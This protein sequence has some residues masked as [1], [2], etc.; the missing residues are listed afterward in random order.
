MAVARRPRGVQRPFDGV[1]SGVDR[2]MTTEL[3][4]VPADYSRV[5]RRRTHLP[6]G[7]RLSLFGFVAL[8]VAPLWAGNL[9]SARQLYHRT[10]YEAALS[11]LEAEGSQDAA[12]LLLAGQTYY[13]LGQYREASERLEKA[14]E[15]RPE[16]AEIFLWLGRS[17]GR[18]AEASSFFTALGHAR[19][20]REALE[21]AVELDGKSLDAMNDLATY[22]LEAP[23]FLGGGVDKA[24]QLAS[25]I[26]S[27]DAAAEH[28]VRARIAEKRRDFSGAEAHLQKAVEMAPR[29]VDPLIKL[30]QF[31][32]RHGKLQQG[33]QALAAAAEVAPESPRLLFARAE[34]YVQ[35]RHNL[36]EAQLLLQRYLR[37]PLTPEDPPRREAERLLAASGR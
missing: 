15:L 7:V 16:S 1:Q 3:K 34:M 23:G 36:R 28:S 18:M 22:Y 19:R 14:S 29:Q 26:A 10:A 30:A 25:R 24:V 11:A 17:F 21:R 2:R 13:Q 12:V 32:A 8:L 37:M 9:D 27:L 4:P 31:F 5:G 33:E 35:Q 6:V 20:C